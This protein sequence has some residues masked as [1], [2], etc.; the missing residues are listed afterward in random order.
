M[1]IT[2]DSDRADAFTGRVLGD[3]AATATTVLAALG[4]RLGLFKELGHGP[5]T[6]SELAART[7]TNERYVR[8][9][10][11]GLYAAGYLEYDAAARTYALPAAHRPTLAD[12]P[13]PAFFGGVLQELLG[14]VQRYDQV[15]NAFRSGGGVD[16]EELHEDVWL[17]TERF[18][19]QWHEN[20]LVQQWLPL[21]PDVQAALRSGTTAADVGCGAGLAVTRLATE[22][23]AST[24]V[25]YDEHP[26]NIERARKRAAG[27]G[28]DDRVRFELLDVARGL[29]ER[30][31]VITA[32]DVIHD[33]VDPAA[34]LR[35]IH[36]ALTPG[37]VFVCLDINCSD[38]TE[39]NVGPI[40]ALLYGISMMYCLTTSLARGG[41]GLGTLG[42]PEPVLRELASAAG[43][44]DL[45]QVDLGNPFNNLYELRR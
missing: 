13:G 26:A 9:W 41:H 44:S 4:D 36:D 37:G 14:A 25:G 5:L 2:I 40:A 30:A 24:F 21:L 23:P 39:D 1:T 15:L 18:T 7:G 29:P 20:L 10:S 19:T 3:A 38:R 6:S 27:L 33:A 11:A 28:V 16:P 34:L 8:E 43:F 42:L 17:G 35:S 45:R 22:F 31:G 32:F 12:E